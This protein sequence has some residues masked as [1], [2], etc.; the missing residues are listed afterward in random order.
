M[1]FAPNI[2]FSKA[3]AIIFQ[4]SSRSLHSEAIGRNQTPHASADGLSIAI[5]FCDS[6]CH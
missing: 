5:E 1:F 6:N 2:S 3:E 4:L